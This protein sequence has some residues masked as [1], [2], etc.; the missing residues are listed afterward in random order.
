MSR[1]QGLRPCVDA[2]PVPRREGPIFSFCLFSHFFAHSG[3]LP[4]PTSLNSPNSPPNCPG[5]EIYVHCQVPRLLW[6]VRLPTPSSHVPNPSS[7]V[8]GGTLGR[9]A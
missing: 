3:L 8:S 5:T 1:R 9:V 2:H 4:F 7:C 6:V